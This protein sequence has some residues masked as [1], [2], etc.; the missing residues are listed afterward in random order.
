MFCIRCGAQ[1]P[2]NALFC[3]VCGADFNKELRNIPVAVEKVEVEKVGNLECLHPYNNMDYEE[4]KVAKKQLRRARRLAD[5]SLGIGIAA[6]SFL[7]LGV[8]LI[9][10]LPLFWFGAFMLGIISFLLAFLSKRSMYELLPNDLYEVQTKKVKI[11]YRKGKIA[12]GIAMVS[13]V[14]GV[15]AFIFAVWYVA[16]T[17]MQS[18]FTE[19]VKLFWEYASGAFGE[20]F[21]QLTSDAITTLVKTI[22]NTIFN[23]IL[24][25]IL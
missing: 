25:V 13:T 15:A 23:I 6:V 17:I 4:D 2:D 11:T 24:S 22:V 5:S 10:T 16:T 14:V 19:A 8:L 7:L 9:P 21:R 1:L 18:D 20:L 3:G 12:S